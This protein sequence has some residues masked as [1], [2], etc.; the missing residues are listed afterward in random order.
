[1]KAALRSSTRT[2][3][4][5][6]ERLR[7]HTRSHR[8]LVIALAKGDNSL[9]LG[10]ARFLKCQQAHDE[11]VALRDKLLEK[12]K[13]KLPPPILFKEINEFLPEIELLIPLHLR[14]FLDDMEGELASQA[15]NE[16]EVTL[17]QLAAGTDERDELA[18]LEEATLDLVRLD[19]YERR[20]WSRQK[21]AVCAFAN[22]KLMQRLGGAALEYKVKG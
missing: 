10:K 1:M 6:G 19:R 15:Q 16:G 2:A 9:A 4:G 14:I 21:R 3:A 12:Y 13:D 7:K 22:I 8:K 11:L 5:P 18:A 20:A 17:N